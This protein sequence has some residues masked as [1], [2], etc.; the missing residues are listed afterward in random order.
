MAM[1]R[2]DTPGIHEYTAVRTPTRIVAV[3]TTPISTVRTPTQRT[4]TKRIVEAYESG[5]PE[6]KIAIAEELGLPTGPK[7]VII[8]QPGPIRTFFDSI[9]PPLAFLPGGSAEGASRI[10]TE[11]P[12]IILKSIFPPA[13]IIEGPT[14][15]PG[16]VAKKAYDELVVEQVK[17]DPDIPQDFKNQFERDFLEAYDKFEKDV[18]TPPE[19]PE[20]K[21]P[22]IKLPEWPKF[23][24]IG[25]AIA[26]VGKWLIIGVVAIAAL[27]GL[28]AIL[29]RRRG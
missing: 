2:F 18:Y 17:E 14:G 8:G 25:G 10:V 12:E 15:T 6:V 19:L 27:I 16:Y 11:H 23:P 4:T 3:E 5:S 22:E 13:A 20:I 24:D 21:I 28:S 7:E 9:V 26:G 29:G 1:T